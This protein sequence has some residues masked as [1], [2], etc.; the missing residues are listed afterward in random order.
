MKRSLGAVAAVLSIALT[1]GCGLLEPA[2]G[3]RSAGTKATPAA[4]SGFGSSVKED[5]DIPDPCPL[6]SRDEVADLT[7]REVTQIDVDGAE[8]GG[9][10]RFCQ[11]Q[12][13]DGQLAV[14]LSRTTA[15]DFQVTIADAEPVDGVGAD[16]YW[17]SAHLYVLYGTVQ[18][19]VYVHGGAEEV[20][21]RADAVE[22]AKVLLPRV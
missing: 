16:A 18:I 21:N 2:L 22:V 13:A 4:R 6:L 17:Q 20:G 14:F 9:A 15:D 11:W 5:G 10:A 7:G 8:P 3:S 1:S 19:D 12:Q